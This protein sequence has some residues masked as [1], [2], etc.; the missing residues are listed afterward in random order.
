MK[1]YSSKNQSEK[2]AGLQANKGGKKQRTDYPTRIILESKYDMTL[3]RD[4]TRNQT[5]K[6]EK[7]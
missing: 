4:H 6:K 2:T 1:K 7:E 5:S 3:G